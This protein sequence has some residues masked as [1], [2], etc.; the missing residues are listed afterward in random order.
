MTAKMERR[1][2][3][4]PSNDPPFSWVVAILSVLIV[5]LWGLMKLFEK[6]GR[7]GMEGIIP[8]YNHYRMFEMAGLEGKQILWLLVPF[9]NIYVYYRFT[10]K[11]ATNFA[12]PQKWLH[13]LGTILPPALWAYIGFKKNFFYRGPEG[14]DLYMFE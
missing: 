11:F 7:S 1:Q 14:D 6:T 8:V 2:S 9:Y 12:L 13:V 5:G 4:K 10:E 3:P